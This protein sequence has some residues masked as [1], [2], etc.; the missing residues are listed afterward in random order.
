MNVARS[1]GQLL[2]L[3]RALVDGTHPTVVAPLIGDSQPLNRH[4]G[5]TAMGILETT[6]AKGAVMTLVQQGGW[7][8]EKRPGPDGQLR[9]GR[10]WE[11][12]PTPALHFSKWSFKVLRMLLKEPLV[13]SAKCPTAPDAPG[14]GDRILALL[15]A[16][17]LVTLNLTHGFGAVQHEPL[18]QLAFPWWVEATPV[19]WP[20]FLKGR[21]WMIEGLHDLLAD[22]W[23]EAQRD[24]IDTR[25]PARVIAGSER[26]RA[27]LTGFLDAIEAMGRRDLADFLLA[28]GERLVPDPALP[29]AFGPRELDTT[30]TLRDRTAAVRGSTAL[31]EALARVQQFNAADRTVRFFDDEY[32][33]TQQRLARWERYSDARAGVVRRAIEQLHA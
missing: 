27:V 29:P 17:A 19:D 2:T 3:A 5:P 13:T 26:Q 22:A 32:E 16:R 9:T 23:V 18:V 14:E 33:A 12:H 15:V 21:E 30:A 11:R 6:L 31:L 1:E 25:S 24:M 8:V 20:A 7:R 28:A 4:V 10:L